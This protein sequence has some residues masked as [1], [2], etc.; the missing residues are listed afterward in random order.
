MPGLLH[1]MAAAPAH[2]LL[3]CW[4]AAA[5]LSQ[6]EA[7]VVLVPAA[8]SG[9]CWPDSLGSLAAVPRLPVLQG[10][11]RVAAVPCL[12]TVV[13]WLGSAAVLGW[14][15]PGPLLQRHAPQAEPPGPLA[16]WLGPQPVRPGYQLQAPVLSASMLWRQLQWTS[17]KCVISDIYRKIHWRAYCWQQSCSCCANELTCKWRHA[18]TVRVSVCCAGKQARTCLAV[19]LQ[20]AAARSALAPW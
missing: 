17:L 13:V 5:V 11:W 12:P 2:A 9:C 10:S 16:Q 4:R 3:G 18:S 1:W 8:L 15:C 20:S 7:G 19:Q 14:Q 6:L